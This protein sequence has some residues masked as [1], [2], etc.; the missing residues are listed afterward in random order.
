MICKVL[1]NTFSDLICTTPKTDAVGATATSVSTYVPSQAHNPLLKTLTTFCVRIFSGRNM[2]GPSQADQNTRELFP[3]ESSQSVRERHWWIDTSIFLPLGPVSIGIWHGPEVRLDSKPF[4]V[5][6]RVQLEWR[7][8]CHSGALLCLYGRSRVPSWEQP[9]IHVWW[10]LVCKY[11]TP[12]LH[13]SE[14]RVVY[15]LPDS[16]VDSSSNCLQWKPAWKWS[17]YC[18][19]LYPISLPT[20]NQFPG[21]TSHINHLHTNF[22]LRVCFW[23]T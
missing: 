19:L 5:L 1:S 20:P 8:S 6:Q 16:P 21:I 4:L 3:W 2:L 13:S 14:P 11:S 18:L 15:W 23:G 7:S 12:F 9:S 17:L 10:E 22:C